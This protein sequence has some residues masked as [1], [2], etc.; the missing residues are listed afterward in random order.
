VR[1]M[2]R[3]G[4]VALATVIVAFGLASSSAQEGAD[5]GDR[6]AQPGP[7][8]LPQG[9]DVVDLDPSEFTTRIDNPYWPMRPGTVWHY[10]E[11]GG[12]EVEK[13]TVRVTRRTRLIEGIRVR[14]V[15]DVVRS[16][17]GEIQENTFDWY[18]QDSGGSIWYFGEHTREYEDGVPVST[19]GS[20]EHGKGGAQAGVVVPAEPRAGCTY[21]EEYL[22]GEAE[23]RAK[24][25]STKEV[26]RTR[27]GMHRGVLQTANTTPLEPDILENKFYARG[28]GPVIEFNA[29]P[30]LGTAKLVR[31]KRP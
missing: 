8:G 25:L 19:E 29:S 2:N 13:V 15:H 10:V 18:A 5:R 6:C 17:D 1:S 30:Q 9:D 14:V 27:F 26:L 3:L 20:F 31:F 16:A 23:D 22:A 4:L 12:G 7:Y 21:R 28:I 11:R 24:V